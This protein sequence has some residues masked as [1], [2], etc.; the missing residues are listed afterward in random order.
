[1]NN[2]NNEKKW[3]QPA[4]KL[5]GELT[6]WVAG[7]IIVAVFVGDWLDERYNKSPWIFLISIGIAFIITNI[8]VV[9]KS[10]QAMNEIS[11]NS[12]K[13]EKNKK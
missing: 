11:S 5:F 1:M 9:K 7:P 10:I 8:A 2:E 13:T 6:A 4:M 12:K 3:W